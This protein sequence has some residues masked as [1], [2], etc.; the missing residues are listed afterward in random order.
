MIYVFNRCPYKLPGNISQEYRSIH[1]KM[2]QMNYDSIHLTVRP[3][4][5]LHVLLSAYFSFYLRPS[6]RLSIHPTACASVCGYVYVRPSIAGGWRRRR[7]LL[8]Q[9]EMEGGR[10]RRRRR[11]LGLMC[12][13]FSTMDSHRRNI[14]DR[15]NTEV[16]SSPSSSSPAAE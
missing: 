13:L 7:W 6:I 8:R 15:F 1:L 2:S 16:A 4:I 9:R 11:P 3:C 10:Q 14:G 12:V 5:C